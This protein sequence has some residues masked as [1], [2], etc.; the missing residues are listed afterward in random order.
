MK[1]KLFALLL[2]LWLLPTPLFSASAGTAPDE[3]ETFVL[4]SEED[5]PPAGAEEETDLNEWIAELFGLSGETEEAAGTEN[6]EEIKT[7]DAPVSPVLTVGASDGERWENPDTGFKI[8]LLDDDDLLTPGEE[9]KLLEDMQPITRYGHVIFWSTT[10]PTVDPVEQARLKRR[11]LTFPDSAGIF[12]INMKARKITFQSYGKINDAVSSS[13]A[14]TVT[15]NVSHYATDENYYR[16]ASEG[17]SQVYRLLEGER[18]AQPMKY[19]SYAM[20]SLML[21]LLLSS[22][23]VFGKRQNTVYKTILLPLSLASVAGLLFK[24]A[25]AIRFDRKNSRYDPLPDDSSS[26]SSSSGCGGGGGGG[27][28]GGGSS[29]F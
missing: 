25:P 22:L 17:F 29:S 20:L 7:A 4:F 24:G 16:C 1:N 27:C 11:A 6:G 15:D 2:C 23:F 19:L 8:W 13:Y 5:A 12:V 26:S 18:I 28:G 3:E 14:R 9:A 10:E 21:G